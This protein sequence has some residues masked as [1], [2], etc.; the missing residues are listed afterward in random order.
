MDG[1]NFLTHAGQFCSTRTEHQGVLGVVEKVLSDLR[2]EGKRLA[3]VLSSENAMESEEFAGYQ[4]L[5]V[6]IS[7]KIQEITKEK[8]VSVVRSS[9]NSATSSQNPTPDQSVLTPGVSSLK[10]EEGNTGQTQ[11]PKQTA[12]LDVSG[13]RQGG[14]LGR[15][16]SSAMGWKQE[17]VDLT[18]PSHVPAGT[19]SN[20]TIS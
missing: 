10:A 12:K 9:V 17:A 6:E 14:G 13:L 19:K 16:I 2:G 1:L 7:E 3:Y 4:A 5:E 20:C 8:T 18:S 11:G 15:G